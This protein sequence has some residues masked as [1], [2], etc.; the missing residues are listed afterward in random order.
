MLGLDSKGNQSQSLHVRGLGQS[1]VFECFQRVTP[2]RAIEVLQNW[3]PIGEA[4]QKACRLT[5]DEGKTEQ[6]GL[7]QRLELSGEHLDLTVIHRNKAPVLFPGGIVDLLDRTDFAVEVLEI[8]PSS[9]HTR[10]AFPR[11]VRQLLQPLEAPA[12]HR[13][14]KGQKVLRLVV[15]CTLDQPRI[16]RRIVGHHHHG[17]TFETV[18][19]EAT[20]VVR[21]GIERTEHRIRSSLPAP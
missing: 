4:Q 20:L 15:S 11:S 9:L 5:V 3:I 6:P 14:H 16:I 8:G 19:Q 13:G 18:D 12:L 2:R 17:R 7:D 21:R 1:Q 10:I